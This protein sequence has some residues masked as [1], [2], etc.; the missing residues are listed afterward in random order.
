MSLTAAAGGA[1]IYLQAIYRKVFSYS[2]V[3]VP[4]L[5]KAVS[6]LD[7]A[8][9]YFSRRPGSNGK[10]VSVMSLP[11]FQRSRRVL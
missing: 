4:L 8:F 6:N 5:Q 11:P 1:I 9:C 2:L 7:T 10:S 3:A